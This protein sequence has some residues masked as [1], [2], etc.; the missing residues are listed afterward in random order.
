MSVPLLDAVAVVVA[1]LLTALG[2]RLA[3]LDSVP[4]RPLWLNHGL[5]RR[6][7]GVVV[8]YPA[9]LARLAGVALLLYA[10]GLVMVTVSFGAVLSGAT[11]PGWTVFGGWPLLAG[12]GISLYVMLRL[13]VR[14]S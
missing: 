11:P 8:E 5:T 12:V 1:L 14:A 10:V 2:A 9:G 7:Q 4:E 13:R 3:W 6:R